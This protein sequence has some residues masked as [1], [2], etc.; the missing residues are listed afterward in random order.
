M[1]QAVLRPR[2]WE[3]DTKSQRN[4]IQKEVC[5]SLSNK[6]ARV[7]ETWMDFTE[8]AEVDVAQDIN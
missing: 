5:D 4:A 6:E 1:W 8:W 2:V 3:R 7:T